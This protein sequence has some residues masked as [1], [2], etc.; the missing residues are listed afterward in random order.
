VVTT[1][2]QRIYKAVRRIPRGRVATYGQIAELA[3]LEGHARQVGY[4]LH[5]LPSKSNVPWHRVIN[6][7]GEISLRGGSDSHELQRFLLEAEGIAFDE[8]G[9][10]DL[11]RWQ[12]KVRGSRFDLRVKR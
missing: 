5:A 2:Y 3:G 10:A 6:A 9:R 1:T 7:R 4:A 12:W 8:E 11:R